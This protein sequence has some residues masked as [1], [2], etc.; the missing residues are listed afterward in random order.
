MSAET[1]LK[2]LPK[3]DPS[4]KGQLE[5]FTPDKLK[6]TDTEEKT[7]LPSKEDIEKEKGQQA[8]FQGIEGFNSANLK[9][10][11]TQEKNPLPTKEVIEQEKNA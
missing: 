9:K 4:L 1:A 10:T 7:V 5:G 6:K 11:E 3:V 2:D 8:L